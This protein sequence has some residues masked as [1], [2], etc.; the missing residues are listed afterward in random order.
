M[1][2]AGRIA[3]LVGGVLRGDAARV[4]TRLA[5]IEQ[6]GEN[7]V[8][9]LS[10]KKH[11]PLLTDCTAGVVLLKESLAG[12]YTGDVIV[13]ED[14]YLAFATISSVF[15]PEPPVAI[16]IHPSAVVA[17]TATLGEG[18]VIGA[19]AVI[20]AHVTLAAGVRIGPNVTIGDGS[21]IGA[22]SW[23][24]PNVT[25][26]HQVIVGSRCRIHS[27]SV[28]GSHGFGYANHQGNW[29]KIA[30]IGRLVI[31]NDVEIGANCAVDRGAIED[32]VIEDGVKID[33]LVHIAHNVRIG[34]HT[35][36][37]GQVGISGSTS[38]GHHTMVG[39]QS[40]FAGHLTTAPGTIFTGQCMVTGNVTEPGMYS[41]GT[42]LSPAKSWRKMV[43]RM[44]HIDE[45]HKQVQ[46]LEKR[47]ENLLPSGNEASDAPGKDDSN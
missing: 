36:L 4:I 13:V 7:A 28:L 14:A 5:A 10:D 38:I 11:R 29:S 37:A 33:N 40:G 18:V 46:Q 35:A 1:I 23:L 15:D 25:V 31:G 42:G 27:G 24:Y 20:G 16:D 30:Q 8:T 34:A 43:A 41:S 3:A 26:Y 6:A 12:D 32:T 45:L 19:H 2:T 17:D 21:M 9:F 47:L 22:D 44:R 39:G